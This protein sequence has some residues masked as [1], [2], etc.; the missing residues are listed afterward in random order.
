MPVFVPGVDRWH[1]DLRSAVSLSPTRVEPGA[2][3]VRHTLQIQCH[4][5]RP[6]TGEL[7]LEA[8]AGWQIVPRHFPFSVL[9][10]RPFLQTVEI[11]Y[12]HNE[13]AGVKR[14]VAMISTEGAA[15]RL[16]VPLAIE[17]ALSDVE[18][19]GAAYVEDGT[20][21]LRH[22]VANRSSQ[23]LSF[24]GAAT[25]PGRERQYRPISNLLPGDS[26]EVQYRIPHAQNLVGRTVHLSLR[27]VNDG[28]R[29]HTLQLMVP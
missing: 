2:D 8:S 19:R 22:T 23:P 10:H 4:G 3:V 15:Y 24:R 25:V 27:E 26:Q 16:E 20:L 1:L 29:V 13:P 18:V 12:P 6:V 11:R 5:G 17:I 7:S 14:I 9:P 21:I 28:P